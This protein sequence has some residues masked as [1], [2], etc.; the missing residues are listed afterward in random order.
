LDELVN[1]QE[2]WI[3]LKNYV[4]N[5]VLIMI[6]HYIRINVS[7]IQYEDKLT[8]TDNRIEWRRPILSD[9]HSLDSQTADV[10]VICEGGTKIAKEIDVK[11]FMNWH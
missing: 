4:S 2:S 8:T 1:N 5:I 11:A 9:L 10:N 6:K 3:M 7:R